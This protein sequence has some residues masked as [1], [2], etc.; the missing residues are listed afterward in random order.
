MQH[1]STKNH[2]VDYFAKH[3][4]CK[5]TVG[6]ILHCWFCLPVCYHWATEL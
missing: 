1:Y 4:H 3:T 2:Y 6:Q 5:L